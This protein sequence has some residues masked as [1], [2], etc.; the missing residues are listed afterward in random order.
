MPGA[1]TVT[2]NSSIITLLR[3]AGGV[4]AM[5]A[6][7]LYIERT[8]ELGHLE[9]YRIELQDPVRSGATHWLREGDKV[10][11]PRAEQYS[12]VGEVQKPGSYRL[13]AS[14]TVTQ[15]IAK[16][17]GVTI[18]ASNLASR[19]RVEIRRKNSDGKEVVLKVEPDDFVEPDDV[20][21]VKGNFF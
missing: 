21:R 10:V 1:Y 16:A 19:R 14:M 18:W 9:R 20:I 15:A 5:G 7:S 6:D 3:Q 11:V 2:A 12:I 17:G 13:D 8:N 4:T